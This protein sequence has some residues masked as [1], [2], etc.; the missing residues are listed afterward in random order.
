M[1]LA[2]ITVDRLSRRFISGRRNNRRVLDAVRGIS[3]EVDRGERL[4]FIGP[5][6]A[7]K[8]TSIK[9]LTGVLYPT[10]GAAR[11]LDLVP[12]EQRRTLTRRI[13]TLFGQRSQLWQE[14]TPRTSFR[15][16]GAI[17]SISR[18]GR[19]RSGNGCAASSPRACC[20]NPR[21]CSSTNRQ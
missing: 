4:A 16:L 21:R 9:I 14:L 7:G 19:N 2:A 6:G 1:A 10:S 20:T 15:M 12:W 11:V 18:C 5:N 17:S 13:G 3:F 8:S